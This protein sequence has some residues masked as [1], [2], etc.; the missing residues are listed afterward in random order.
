MFY[1]Q[2]IWKFFLLPFALGLLVSTSVFGGDYHTTV[3]LPTDAKCASGDSEVLII[4]EVADF[5]QINDVGKTIFCVAPGDYTVD[6]DL[7]RSGT[8]GTPRYIRY[9]KSGEFGEPHPANMIEADRAVIEELFF[10]SNTEYW[11]V[12]RI[13]VR[14]AVTHSAV[15]LQP[16][17][18]NNIILNR[19]LIEDTLGSSGMV[20]GGGDNNVIQD[21]VIRNSGFQVG[22]D[23]HCLVFYG[24]NFKVVGNEIYNCAGDMI[25]ISGAATGGVIADNELYV[26]E[27]YYTDC[28]GN[29]DPNGDCMCVENGLDF[30]GGALQANDFPFAV[31]EQLLVKGNKIWGF[32]RNDDDTGGQCG[33]GASSIGVAVIIHG[34]PGEGIR[35]ENNII[36]SGDNN[37][38]SAAI[39]GANP[40]AR[41]YSFINNLFY[42][43]NYTVSLP[44][45]KTHHHEFLYN[46]FLN[47]GITKLNLGWGDFNDW[48]CN[49]F[50]NITDNGLA[51]IG[52]SELY[53]YNAYYNADN[54]FTANTNDE[55][56]ATA[57]ESNNTTFSWTKFHITNPT[58][59]NVS[60]ASTT[61][62]SPHADLCAAPTETANR[63]VDDVTMLTRLEAGFKAPPLTLTIEAEDYNRKV[64]HKGTW[65]VVEDTELSAAKGV[66]AP[67]PT[68]LSDHQTS[69]PRLEYNFVVPTSGTYHIWF[70]AKASG[71]G[72]NSINYTVGER[73]K[74][75][76]GFPYHGTAWT[77]G[78]ID[79][80]PLPAGPHKLMVWKRERGTILDKIII[81]NNPDFNIQKLPN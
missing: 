38:A 61:T 77:K 43:L 26:D 15:R 16:G 34:K 18:G 42:D 24:D 58:Q 46:T 54:S 28:A 40:T 17:G 68:G 81:T 78:V 66:K 41:H 21:S 52:T 49:V 10:L 70:R 3:M 74:K 71:P 63:G 4:D 19:M 32:N 72:T 62:S 50:I 69:S 9:Y 5:S 37:I 76:I 27:N 29:L 44:T 33:T 6:L 8:A 36:T 39:I 23:D 2:T 35:F 12:D 60:L 56:Y 51:Q 14:D 48:Q 20:A 65:E 22:F 53:D 30:K 59:V 55:D 13:T 45:T 31:S 7:T 1:F 11:I 73:P 75:I 80:S 64:S 79:L 67:T 57:A 47:S 25:Q